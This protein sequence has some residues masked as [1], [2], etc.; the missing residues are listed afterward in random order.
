MTQDAL[1]HDANGL[2]S[3]IP[4]SQVTLVEGSTF[5]VCDHGGS[6]NPDHAQG[7]F[8]SDARV[9]SRWHLTVNGREIEA[10]GVVP[11]APY[12][13]TF[14]GRAAGTAEGPE[15]TLLIER[16]RTIFR[17]M[18]EELAIRNFGIEAAGVDVSLAVGVDFADLFHVK[19]HRHSSPT[20]LESH[21]NA[22]ELTV[23]R[24]TDVDQR[25]VRIR[26]DGAFAHHG[27][28]TLRALV[29]AGGVWTA[30]FEVVPG[31]QS[32]VAPDDG[33][34]L[35]EGVQADSPE[36]APAERLRAW[37]ESLPRI[38]VSHPGLAQALE[39]SG[40][41]VG[42]L[43]IFDPTS[44]KESAVAAG[45][46]W[47]MTLFGRD[48]L[49]TSW[50]LMPYAPDLA[51]GTLR[52]LARLQGTKEDPFTEEQPGRILHEVRSG[53]DLGAALGGSG[54]YYGSVDATAL[55]VMLAGRA[56]EWG[57]SEAAMTELRPHIE[58]AVKWIVDYGDRDGDGLVEYKRSSDRGLINQGWK[59]SSDSMAFATGTQ[60]AA[61]IA[62]SEAQGYAY[63]AFRAYGALLNAWGEDGSAWVERA[64]QLKRQFH[65]AF[66]SA[67]L[68]TYV[69]ALDRDKAP[70][71]VSSSNIGHCLWTGIVAEE[72][73]DSVVRRLVG[74]DMFNGWGIRTL[75]TDAARFNPVSYHNGSVWPHDSTIAAA[76]MAR[77]G[78]MDEAGV[79]VRGL[80]DAARAFGG[81]LP[82]LFCG[83]DRAESA[84]PVPYPTSCSPQAW[85]AAAP[86]E[87]LSIALQLEPHRASHTLAA[88]P[89]AFGLGRARIEG[90]R[91]GGTRVS[92]EADA[93]GVELT[94]PSD[95]KLE[96]TG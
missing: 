26:A 9:I 21:A 50:M 52:T 70:L 15:P 27:G 63:A 19:E 6:I 14:Y 94:A 57:A 49:I 54:V 68:G 43:R 39:Q 87:W 93:E 76:G 23:T 7:L 58:A 42:A 44:P 32:A 56:W 16:K 38:G 72:V 25:S 66:W 22:D 2:P 74:P 69:M 88:G 75:S 59:D 83:L 35:R 40:R 92:L 31:K 64:A 86:F 80:L 78:F 4:A 62:L 8:V 96:R 37:H 61:P 20:G 46:P 10:L 85:A 11:G 3:V 29:P 84:A 95:V 24:S 90:L 65:E 60:A 5:C 1:S 30:T 67:E 18:R 48:S 45:A 82:E 55:F 51:L 89:L 71:Q 34:S 13:A 81:R 91:F 28:L 12:E 77:Y 33:R 36:G 79:V 41:D 53:T 73:A 47:F 17:G